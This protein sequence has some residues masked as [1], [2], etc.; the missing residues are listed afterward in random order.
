MRHRAEACFDGVAIEERTENPRPKQARR[1]PRNGGIERSK[2][3]GRAAARRFFRKNRSNELDIADRNGIEYKRI[4]LLVI[5]IAIEMAQR[6]QRSYS[7][8]VR[9]T[10]T[11]VAAMGGILT[12][13]VND[14]SC[15]GDGLRVRVQAEA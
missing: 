14:C 12:Q 8:A 3:R 9:S 10:I 1:H 4:V 5:A 7:I 15:R 11:G 2:Q 13:I 6:F